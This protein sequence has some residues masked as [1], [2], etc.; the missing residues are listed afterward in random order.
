MV[1]PEIIGNAAKQCQAMLM[2]TNTM[3][4]LPVMGKRHGKGVTLQ[5]DKHRCLELPRPTAGS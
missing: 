4:D 2:P 1:M 3:L 5:T